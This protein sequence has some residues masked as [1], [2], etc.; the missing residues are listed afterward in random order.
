MVDRK[1]I[2][3]SNF[4]DTVME[5]WDNYLVVLVGSH[6]YLADRRQTFRGTQSTEY[7]WYYWTDIGAYDANGTDF[8]PAT[9]L[10]AH[11]SI[12]YFAASDGSVLRFDGTHDDGHLIES[13]WTTPMDDF[14]APIYLK[15]INRKGCVAQV[16]RIPNSII[17]VDVMTDSESR[18]N[19]YAGSTKGFSFVQGTFTF[20]GL[21]FG[22]GVRGSIVFRFKRKRMKEIS[23]RFYSDEIGKPFGLYEATM[24]AAIM[25]Y[26]RS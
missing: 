5:I 22:T 20:D 16:K 15:A 17:K 24:Q 7:E 14:G 18:S 10:K 1:L 8:Y 13:Y 3:E 19:V 12:L 4:T 23:L 25:N 2:N 9:L 21:S 26:I 11:D 6:L